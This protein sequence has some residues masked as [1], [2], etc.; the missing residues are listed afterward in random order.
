MTKPMH[1][2]AAHPP[3]LGNGLSCAESVLLGRA[4]VAT[5]GQGTGV[6]QAQG[7]GECVGEMQMFKHVPNR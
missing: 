2:Q 6:R 7:R 4:W 3:A 5:M 1:K